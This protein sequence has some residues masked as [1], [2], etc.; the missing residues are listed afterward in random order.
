M[1]QIFTFDKKGKFV[2]YKNVEGFPQ[3]VEKKAE[4]SKS[5]SI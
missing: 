4:D 3:K 1:N 5:K 2:R